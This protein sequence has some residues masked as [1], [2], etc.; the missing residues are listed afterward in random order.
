MTTDN[1][2]ALRV[3]RAA[4]NWSQVE[5]AEIS[6]INREGISTYERNERKPSYFA[7][8]CLRGAYGEALTTAEKH[9]GE[10]QTRERG[11][12]KAAS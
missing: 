8:E 5:A 4:L 10:V 2:L 9:Y 7:L 12:A 3:A 6:G 11:R 1:G